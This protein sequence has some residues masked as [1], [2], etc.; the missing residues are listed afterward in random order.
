[1]STTGAIIPGQATLRFPV[2]MVTVIDGI[3][4]TAAELASRLRLVVEI[5]SGKAA[6][7][8][9][10]DRRVY[11]VVVIDQ[12]FAETDPASAELIWTRA[13]QAIPLQINFA[14]AGRNR[15]ELEMR[16]ALARRE[17][18]QALA[19]AA[20]LA[21]VNAEIRDAVTSFLLESRL[22]LT[23]ADVTPALRMRLETL[24]GI[25]GRLQQMLVVSGNLH[26]TTGGLPPPMG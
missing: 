12:L 20:A 23:E 22:A 4:S 17:R 15:I 8:R 5:A 1:M 7:I 10:L 2:L 16:S 13:G 19:A 26:G 14:L 18:E 24:S 21:Q 11:S 25:A 3:E 6:A 9:L